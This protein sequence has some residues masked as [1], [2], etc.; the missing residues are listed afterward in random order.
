MV[1]GWEM[2]F[3]IRRIADFPWDKNWEKQN[4][5][6]SL[7]IYLFVSLE[8]HEIDDFLLLCVCL[9]HYLDS[10]GNHSSFYVLVK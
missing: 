2:E 3:K 8:T 6:H 4:H 1:K 10:L 7:S 9:L 5:R